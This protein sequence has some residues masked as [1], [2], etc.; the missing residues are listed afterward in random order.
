[1]YIMNV[2]E[3]P[4][5]MYIQRLLLTLNG[6]D[7]FEVTLGVYFEYIKVQRKIFIKYITTYIDTNSVL[8]V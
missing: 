5:Y 8:I 7:I 2:Y 1:M 4:Y 3:W 6:L